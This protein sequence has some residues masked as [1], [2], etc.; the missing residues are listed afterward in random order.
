MRGMIKYHD[1]FLRAK[2][3]SLRAKRVLERSPG[4][5]GNHVPTALASFCFSDPFLQGD[6][7]LLVIV[8]V[9][10]SLTQVSIITLLM[11]RETTNT[12]LNLDFLRHVFFTHFDEPCVPVLDF[13]FISVDFENQ[14]LPSILNHMEKIL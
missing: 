2:T 10:R 5:G 12:A 14:K 3:A 13:H 7:N 4:E 6:E 11:P 1:V 9:H 8:L